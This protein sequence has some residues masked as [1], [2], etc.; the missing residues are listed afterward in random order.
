MLIFPDYESFSH[1]K[2]IILTLWHTVVRSLLKNIFYKLYIIAKGEII[3]AMGD[4]ELFFEKVNEDE[5]LK[6]KISKIE[7]NLAN[8]D[9]NQAEKIFNSDILPI[10]QK[11]GFDFSY[12]DVL[13]F[14]INPAHETKGELSDDDLGQVAGGMSC[15][16]IGASQVGESCFIAGQNRSDYH[17]TIEGRKMR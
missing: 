12:E 15:G 5:N 13:N 7:A 1:K 11:L 9:K 6:K 14:S 3:L 10:A 2:Y 17:L 16:V 8:L 4:V